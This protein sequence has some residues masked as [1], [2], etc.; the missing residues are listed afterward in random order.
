MAQGLI[1]FLKSIVAKK[2]IK[3]VVVKR[4]RLA[5]AY[6]DELDSRMSDRQVSNVFYRDGGQGILVRVHLFKKVGF[7]SFHF[8]RNSD[9][10]DL[11]LRSWM[12]ALHEELKDL[13][14]RAVGDGR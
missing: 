4:K 9:I 3:L 13:A 11:K 14:P 5:R 12:K 1:F 10:N 7:G 6:A 2:E 8:I